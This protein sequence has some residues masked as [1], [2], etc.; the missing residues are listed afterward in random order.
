MGLSICYGI[1]KEHNGNIYAS[2]LSGGGAV[3]TVELPVVEPVMEFETEEESADTA[4]L[5]S[6]RI[7]V[8]DDELSIQDMLVDMLSADGHK[9]D[10]A[11][12]GQVA[13]E[14][15]RTRGYDLIISDIKMPGMNGRSFYEYLS[16]V[17]PATVSYTHLTL[18]T[19]RIV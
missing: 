17:N 18:P 4:S 3:L 14:K 10:T 7:L 6:L 19:K 5:P 2:N 12:N 8:V 1:I 15:L 11:S 16:G 13:L 9:V